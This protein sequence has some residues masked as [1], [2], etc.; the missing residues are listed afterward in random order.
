[1]APRSIPAAVRDAQARAESALC[2]GAI[3]SRDSDDHVPAA[4]QLAQRP[5]LD[6]TPRQTYDAFADQRASSERSA[7]PSSAPPRLATNQ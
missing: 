7:A 4:A 1:M 3:H 6:N 2:T 5:A